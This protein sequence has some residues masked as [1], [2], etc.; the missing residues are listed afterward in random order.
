MAISLATLG[1]DG[2][3]NLTIIKADGEDT[4]LFVTDHAQI[5]SGQ[6]FSVLLQTKTLTKV[7]AEKKN[8]VNPIREP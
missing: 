5:A 4:Q 2:P 3:A 1:I 7:E 8:M 6:R